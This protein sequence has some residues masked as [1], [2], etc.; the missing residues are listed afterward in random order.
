MNYT[1][2]IGFASLSKLYLGSASWKGQYLNH[3]SEFSNLQLLDPVNTPNAIGYLTGSAN[4]ST[5]AISLAVN[6]ISYSKNEFS[7]LYSPIEKIPYSSLSIKNSV[8]SALASIHGNI[9]NIPFCVALD[10]SLLKKT[11]EDEGIINIL[12]KLKSKNDWQGILNLFYPLNT[13]NSKPHIWNNPFILDTISF[14]AAKLSETCINLKFAFK[15]DIEKNNFLK[16]QKELRNL[17][18]ELRKRCIDLNPDYPA[19]YSNLAYSYYQSCRELLFPGGR[20]DG[21]LLQDANLALDYLNKALNLDP[22]R[23]T[24]QYRKGQILSVILPPNILFKSGKNPSP[25]DI[26]KVRDIINEGITCFKNTENAYEIIPLIDE[27]NLIRYKKE[28]IKSLYNSARS[29]S[30]L[31]LTDLDLLQTL[32]NGNAYIDSSPDFFNFEIQNIDNAINYI[33]KCIYK[34]N[35]EYS[36]SNN[37]PDSFIVAD[38]NG[39]IDSVFKLYS[40]GKYYFQ[41]Y[42]IL[43][44]VND[45]HNAEEFRFLA[46][47]FFKKAISANFSKNFSAQNKNFIYEK[48]A[49]L[50]ITKNEFHKAQKLLEKI[51]ARNTDYYIRYTYAVAAYLAGNL[52]QS[53]FQLKKAI[54]NPKHNKDL[55][56]G[57]DMLKFIQNKS[58]N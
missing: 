15:S 34:D 49:R 56:K 44:S 29:Y 36:K 13:I 37:P 18:I 8:K 6:E 5:N 55:Q 16:K 41:K 10:N 47:K 48:L 30:D 58:V 20:R 26:K 23:I 51:V 24:D 39:I 50:L 38:F 4:N 21:K 22:G 46:E 1:L 33:E 53:S 9:M 31:V 57:Y 52:S 17:A 35:S 28:Y 12:N 32:K 42:L 3:I 40:A 27:K 14:A 19:Y 2:I 7:I 45:S 25:D 11:L 43:A 54:E